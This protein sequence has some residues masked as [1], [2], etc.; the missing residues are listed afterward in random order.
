MAHYL[1]NTNVVSLHGSLSH[2]EVQRHALDGM[3]AVTALE[4]GAVLISSDALFARLALSNR[5][6]G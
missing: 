2:R 6:C 4:H 3:I 5:R 1:L